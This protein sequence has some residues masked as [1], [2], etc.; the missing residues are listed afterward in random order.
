MDEA[1]KEKLKIERYKA[2]RAH[3][4]EFNRATAAF[5]HA[6][7]Q[8]LYYLNGGAIGVYMTLL[9]AMI[10]PGKPMANTVPLIFTVAPVI[11]WSAGLLIAALA[12][13]YSYKSQRAF[14]K[15]V[16]NSRTLLELEFL[17]QSND[18]NPKANLEDK[19]RT[20]NLSN[21]KDFQTTATGLGLL[22][23]LSFV[24]GALLAAA[25]IARM[26]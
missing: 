17:A 24:A 11:G 18:A 5:E 10:E 9:T 2:V 8:P 3:E 14:S 15:S 20:Q 26:S 21:G 12:T 6:S 22:S 4:L 7:L 25:T 16:R 1:L 19:E 23:I 13:Y